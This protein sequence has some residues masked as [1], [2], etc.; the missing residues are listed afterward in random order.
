MTDTE[1]HAVSLL[2]TEGAGL[3]QPVASRAAKC[4]FPTHSLQT[5][6][7][8]VLAW[9]LRWLQPSWSARTCYAWPMLSPAW[10]VHQTPG[11]GR[12]EHH[13]CVCWGGGVYSTRP[14]LG[15]T[16]YDVFIPWCV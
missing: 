13:V 2:Q 1:A 10:N 8:S 11:G 6:L 14:L 7:P 4:K 3:V 9:L 15:P 12:A 5:Q 16:W